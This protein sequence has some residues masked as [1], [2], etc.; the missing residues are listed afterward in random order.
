MDTNAVA[1]VLAGGTNSRMGAD[2][3]ALE[4]GGEMF[5][6]RIVMILH[7]RFDVVLVC[8]GERAPAGTVL[9]PDPEPGGGPLAGVAGACAAAEG[10]DVFVT[11]VDLPLLDLDVIDSIAA[12]LLSDTQARIARVSGRPQPLCGLY[13]GG[14]GPL[15]ADV[16]G[17]ADRSMMAFL[18]RVPHLTLVD[19]PEGPLRNINTP[20]DYASLSV[21]AWE[22][23][24]SSREPRQNG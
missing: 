2:K 14:L 8:G 7:E 15:V 9:V 19:V 12:P 13:G 4:I 11:A 20:E 23:G 3:A 24:T 18:R 17:S 1:A 6:D 5:L 10:R 21:L 16:L 22:T